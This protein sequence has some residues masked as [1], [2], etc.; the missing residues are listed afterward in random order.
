MCHHTWKCPLH[1]TTLIILFPEQCGH[2][3][4]NLVPHPLSWYACSS[5]PVDQ[6]LSLG[7][8]LFLQQ[9]LEISRQGLDSC[10]GKGI[11][12]L[13]WV[14]DRH[15]LNSLQFTVHT[16]SLMDLLPPTP[17]WLRLRHSAPECGL[18][19]LGALS[20]LFHCLCFLI[21]ART[22][23]GDSGSTGQVSGVT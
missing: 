2:S 20:E 22:P 21:C 8:N 7:G 4:C 3:L 23:Q 13:Q 16:P 11:P 5:F 18:L 12:D 17:V 19:G 10:Q 15:L 14:V 9:N 6:Q 1:I